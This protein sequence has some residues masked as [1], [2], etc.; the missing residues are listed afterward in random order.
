[1]NGN[2]P[3]IIAGAILAWLR[4]TRQLSGGQNV[5]ELDSVIGTSRGLVRSENQDK[6]LIARQGDQGWICS[7]L[8][9][10]IGGM[11]DGGLAAEIAVCRFIESI[12]E[13]SFAPP[14]ERLLRASEYANINVHRRLSEKGGTTLAALFVDKL[15]GVYGVTVGDTRIYKVIP[16]A[17]LEQISFDDTIAGEL[18]RIRGSEFQP[19]ES[20]P[21]ARHLSQFI[22]MGPGLQSRIYGP[23]DGDGWL[24]LTTDGIHSMPTKAMEHIAIH[25]PS[26]YKLATRLIQVSEWVGGFDNAS[27]VVSPARAKAP[28]FQADEDHIPGTLEIW[29]HFGKMHLVLGHQTGP[30]VYSTPL[31]N[32]SE[33]QLEGSPRPISPDLQQKTR[34]SDKKYGRKR[35]RKH[36]EKALPQL[37]MELI[38]AEQ[39]PLESVREREVS[40]KVESDVPTTEL[41]SPSA[42]EQCAKDESDKSHDPI[43][44]VPQDSQGEI[45]E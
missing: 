9:D 42:L 20:D 21:T 17:R 14:K 10:G 28:L 38:E 8:C 16:K 35:A 5:E 18:R 3:G 7:V 6:C 37:G 33:P 19:D 11:L 44:L 4:G 13:N 36:L 34:L 32:S 45:A 27:I 24:L 41:S 29:S 23:L 31:S 25:A 15:G 30:R 26:P 43:A 22:G 40:N 39:L 1:M 2:S 12:A